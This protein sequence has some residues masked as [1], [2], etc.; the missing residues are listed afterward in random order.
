MKVKTKATKATKIS[1]YQLGRILSKAFGKK[2]FEACQDEEDLLDTLFSGTENFR[3]PFFLGDT[4]IVSEMLPVYNDSAF[5]SSSSLYNILADRSCETALIVDSV[6]SSLN[7]LHFATM[8]DSSGVADKIEEWIYLMSNYDLMVKEVSD[9]K[10]SVI[11]V[12]KLQAF[13][14][15]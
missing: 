12:S 1:T 9:C 13:I 4:F 5:K 2:S 11:I 15:R 10:D 3:A 6:L 7:S 14:R 8:V